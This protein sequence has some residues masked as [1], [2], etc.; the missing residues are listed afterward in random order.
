MKMQGSFILSMWRKCDQEYLH[1]SET[2]HFGILQ[3]STAA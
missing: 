3:I 1:G 2:M